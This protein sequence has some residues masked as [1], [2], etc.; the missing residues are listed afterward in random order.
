MGKSRRSKE[1]RHLILF[2]LV[3]LASVHSGLG[4]EVAG[5]LMVHDLV[6]DLFSF[7]RIAPE[8]KASRAKLFVQ[9]IIRPHPEV[10]DRPQI[11]KTDIG[12]LEQYLTS[13]PAYL[14][15]IEHL[16][17]R[18]EEQLASI[19]AKFLLGC[20]VG[21]VFAQ[22][23]ILFGNLG[24]TQCLVLLGLGRFKFIAQFPGTHR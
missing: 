17:R 5:S 7:L 19:Q 21:S 2:L 11:F 16:H 1:K 22:I 18:F 4:T 12:T 9:L 3:C 14:P 24:F 15:A 6:P 13:L 23:P 20:L 10:Y 8:D